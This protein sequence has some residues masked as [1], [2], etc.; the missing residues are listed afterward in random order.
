MAIPPFVQI[1][2]RSYLV[3]N[4]DLGGKPIDHKTCL[5]ALLEYHAPT[6][7]LLLRPLSRSEDRL[8]RRACRDSQ[9]EAWAGMI[10]KEEDRVHARKK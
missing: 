2:G 6:D 1:N 3:T 5:K 7:I 8:L 9:V 4:F 10:V